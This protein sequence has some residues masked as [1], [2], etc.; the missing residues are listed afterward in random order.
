MHPK[1]PKKLRY[2]FDFNYTVTTE[3]VPQPYPVPPSNPSIL[4]RISSAE[5]E[6]GREF[7]VLNICGNP[8]G[9]EYLAA[10]LVLSAHSEKYDPYFHIHLE[11]E[12]CVETDMDVTIRA[13]AY[14]E[15]LKK[16]EFSEFK[17]SRI[18]LPTLPKRN[19]PKR[20]K[21]GK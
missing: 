8:E 21:P 6:D 1:K 10:M 14:L 19:T 7:P 16:G 5:N 11:D 20:K 2:S 17:G 4:F 12:K 15:T 9:L 18:P 3:G 13:P